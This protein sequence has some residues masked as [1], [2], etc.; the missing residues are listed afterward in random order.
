MQV[1]DRVT[2]VSGNK[3]ECGKVKALSDND[4][5]FVVYHC[6]GDWE[7]FE[8][9]T[10][11]RTPIKDLIE[12]WIPNYVAVEGIA[13]RRE[14]TEDGSIQYHRIAGEWSLS[15]KLVNGELF[16]DELE[17]SPLYHLNGKK[18]VEITRDAWGKDNAG[19]TGCEEFD[20]DLDR[21]Y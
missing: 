11:A 15:A 13:L 14:Y 19:Y 7:R 8:D 21:D 6:D 5:V 2:Y 20:G 10:A 3:A 12:G 9:Y 1:G 17:G 16:A 4:H 18:L